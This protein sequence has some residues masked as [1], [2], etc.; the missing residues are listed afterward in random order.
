MAGF[1][2]G[3]VPR[4][5]LNLA[6]GLRQ[7]VERVD[8]VTVRGSGPLADAVPE[9]IRHTVLG[10]PTRRHPVRRPKRKYQVLLSAGRF[11][12]YLRREN[13]EVVV[14]AGNY[15][16][17][18]AVAGRA[19]SR[20]ATPLIVSHHAQLSIEAKNKPLVRWGVRHLY[21]RAD[22]V[23]AV[24]RGVEADLRE[25]GQLAAARVSTIYNPVVRSDFGERMRAPVS[26]PWLEH[27]TRPV[28]LGIGRLHP[29]KDFPT[30]VRAFAQVRRELPCRLLLLGDAKDD[31]ARAELQALARRLDVSGDL[32]MPGY[33]PDPLPYFARADLFALS[34][35]WEGFGNVLVEAM[36]CRCP[37]VSTDCPSGPAEILDGGRFGPLVPVGSD[38]AMARAI[39]DCLSQEPQRDRLRA[40][41]ERFSVEAAAEQYLEL[42]DGVA[43]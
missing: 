41:A 31:S 20:R 40:R 10:A 16:N 38:G 15:V 29:Q 30:L 4:V 9:G 35:A 11:A 19:L 12:E 25:N 43:A 28:I 3:G 13:P 18:S 17:C 14:S 6:E 1:S 7:S 21:P 8:L 23:V 39:L 24:S 34:S 5:M 36:A 33:V 26:H 27:K 22:A 2:S 42:F 37:V 32:S